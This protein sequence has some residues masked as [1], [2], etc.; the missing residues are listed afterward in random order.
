MVLTFYQLLLQLSCSIPVS[1]IALCAKNY[2]KVM[3]GHHLNAICIICST[4]KTCS[5]LRQSP[6]KKKPVEETVGHSLCLHITLDWF[7][8]L[9]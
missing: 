8:M 7:C 4:T 5:L 6:V 2:F 9:I 3:N 1:Q